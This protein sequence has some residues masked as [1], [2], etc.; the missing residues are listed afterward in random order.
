MSLNMV[1]ALLLLVALPASARK[2]N[3]QLRSLV[4]PPRCADLQLAPLMATCRYREPLP[5]LPG[6][7]AAGRFGSFLVLPR[8]CGGR[9]KKHGRGD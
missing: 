2:S 7:R 3:R 5:L 6:C 1:G 4:L 9:G 8:G